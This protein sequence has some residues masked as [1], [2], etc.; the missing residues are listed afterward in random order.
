MNMDILFSNGQTV[1]EGNQTFFQPIDN[2]WGSYGLRSTVLG[3]DKTLLFQK[4][5]YTKNGTVEIVT[6]LKTK[7]TDLEPA[8]VLGW[9]FTI[10][11]KTK[12][13]A[14]RNNEEFIIGFGIIAE[15]VETTKMD[16]FL[17]RS[18]VVNQLGPILVLNKSTILAN[19]QSYP[20]GIVVRIG[21]EG[22]TGYVLFLHN[23]DQESDHPIRIPSE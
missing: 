8:D 23:D 5:E 3:V 14:H 12:T 21:R 7:I 15:V 22:N 18:H 4:I 6:D 13:K 10:V 1:Q 20:N 11:G 17:G 9:A 2:L 19:L 16:E